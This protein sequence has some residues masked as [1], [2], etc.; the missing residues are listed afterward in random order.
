MLSG[1]AVE[2]G[3]LP[4]ESYLSRV[5]QSPDFLFHLKEIQIL[6]LNLSSIQL[7]LQR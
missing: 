2:P 6:V 3:P 1:L 4:L 7:N 5:K